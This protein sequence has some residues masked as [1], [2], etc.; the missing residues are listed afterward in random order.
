MTKANKRLLLTASLFGATAMLAACASDPPPQT[1]T[2]RTET[3]AVQP[4][5]AQ[6][7][8]PM[9]SQPTQTTRTVTTRTQQSPE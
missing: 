8:Q 9:M 3:T 7:M 4:V 5:Q 2:T 6:P 1:V